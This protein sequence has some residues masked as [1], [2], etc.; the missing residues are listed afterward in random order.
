LARGAAIFQ[1]LISLNSGDT[2]AAG[3]SK[4]GPTGAHPEQA[5]EARSGAARATDK[6]LAARPL[7]FSRADPGRA[8]KA[9]TREGSPIFTLAP[10]TRAKS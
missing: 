5:T 7:A 8:S 1:P 3:R 6:S 10:V 2:I 4:L 9:P